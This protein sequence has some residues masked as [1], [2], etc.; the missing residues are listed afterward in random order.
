MFRGWMNGFGGGLRVVAEEGVEDPVGIA[1]KK[2]VGLKGQTHAPL[3]LAHR[4]E[5]LR[6]PGPEDN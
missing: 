5:L 3:K 1:R 6:C 4:S 2:V